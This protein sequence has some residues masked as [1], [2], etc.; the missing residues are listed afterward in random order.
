[1]RDR[2]RE[3]KNFIHCNPHVLGN[4]PENVAA[5]YETKIEI[6]RGLQWGRRK[7]VLLRWLRKHMN[8]CLS[9]RERRCLELYYLRDLT[10]EQTAAEEKCSL[11]SAHRA[12]RRA[13]NKLRAEAERN[14]PP[15]LRRRRRR[16]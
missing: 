6:A 15:P 5:W 9:P 4:K 1:M 11:S 14:G 2:R 3:R 12:V 16:P 8:E 7:A 10:Y 13:I